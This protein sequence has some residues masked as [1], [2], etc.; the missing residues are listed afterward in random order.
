MADI[1]TTQMRDALAWVTNDQE[2][3]KEPSD[4]PWVWFWEAVQGDFN[5]DRST[6]QILVDAGISMI[7]LV[8]QVC[9]VRD[10]IANCKKLHHDVEDN[11]AWVALA[12]TLIGLFP[13]LGS[14]VKGVL[15]IFF[16]FVRHHGGDDTI[17]AVDQAMTWVITFLRRRDVQKYLQL[18]QVDEVFGWLAKEIKAVRAKINVAELIAAF[19][20]AIK[21]LESLVDKVSLIPIAGKKAT[22]ALEQV[23]KIRLVA[24][25]HLTTALK[26][27]MDRMSAIVMRLEREALERQR[28]VL[29]AGN[30][31]FRGVLPEAHAVTLM[32]KAEPLPS[33]LSKGDATWSSAL[34]IRNRGKVDRLS[35]EKL[36]ESERYPYLHDGNIRSFHK[37]AEDKIEGPATLY[38]VTSPTNRAMGEFWVTE[39][40]FDELKNAPDARAAWRRFLGVWPN[41]NVNGQY[42]KYEIKKGEI[43]NVWRGPTASQVTKHLPD[44]HLEAGWEQVFFSIARSDERNDTMRYYQMKAGNENQLHSSIS[45]GE[46]DKLPEIGRE[47]YTAIRE[48]INHPNITGPFDTGW[49]YTDFGGEGF[50]NKIGLPTLPNSTPP[51]K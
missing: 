46:Y 5:E 11:W 18:H 12:L 37:L 10:L 6:K 17:K 9:D 19:D 8:D 51:L 33:W 43:L 14:L 29:D 44:R 31:H 26:P 47:P 21:L 4:N 2:K 34:P 50:L 48:K 32:R 38:R 45:Q 1:N 28:G 41:W 49:G 13:I 30:I 7:P 40:T 24:N 39:K 23:K 22:A 36:S 42:V 27:V 25:A 20:K 3:A 15:K 16:V 35:N